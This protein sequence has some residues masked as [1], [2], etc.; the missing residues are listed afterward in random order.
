M[1]W[2]DD[3]GFII[4]FYIVYL[5]KTKA[6]HQTRNLEYYKSHQSECYYIVCTWLLS[7][8][9]HCTDRLTT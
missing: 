1:F 8:H 4:K 5:I 2:K 6:K 3:N 9:E 7:V